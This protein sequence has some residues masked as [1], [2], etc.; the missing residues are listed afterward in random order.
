MS[1]KSQIQIH[2]MIVHKVDHRNYDAPQ[3]SDLESPVTDEVGSFLRQHIA[4]NREHKYVRT[5]Q[6]LPPEEGKVS[7]CTICDSLLQH[8]GQFVPQSQKVAEHLFDT[9]DKRVS[10][11]DL[12]L[13]TFTEGDGDSGWLALL[14]MD[15]EDGFVGV[16]E[17]VNGQ[18]RYIL[19]RVPNV[20]PRGELQKCAFILPPDLR[21]ERGYDLK[22]LD[23]QAARYGARRLVASFFVTDFLQCK[24]GLDPVDTT[25]AFVYG[26]YEWLEGKKEQWPQD[27]VERFKSR[28]TDYLQDAVVDVT[29]FGVAV[30]P[31]PDEQDE[32]LEY[33][34]EQGLEDLTFEPDP[35]ERQRLTK[36]IRFEGDHGLEV[37]I[38][39]D[40]VG[41]GKTLEYER[42]P[43][44]NAWVVTI[45]T[46]RWE[47]KLRRGRW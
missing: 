41:P 24:V 37:R 18:V 42:D 40:A 43:V 27:D 4:S 39:T 10:A 13:C 35:R 45:R 20:L 15:P 23:Q 7:V 28:V 5:G 47:E 22:V 38:E 44:T 9:M 25:R 11:G 1:D 3:L 29:N 17:E 6:F 2:R 33:M 34:R 30:I 16:R 21:E 32:Y 31:S 26:S 46:T 8:P 12:I 19:Q 36:Y 14:K